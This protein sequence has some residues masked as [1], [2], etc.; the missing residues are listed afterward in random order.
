MTL[1]L[2]DSRLEVRT[3]VVAPA[4]EARMRARMAVAGW[5]FQYGV[6]RADGTV[7][8]TFARRKLSAREQE[9]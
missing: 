1:T 5:K 8:L 3:L 6:Q 4:H 9:A 2:D 7:A